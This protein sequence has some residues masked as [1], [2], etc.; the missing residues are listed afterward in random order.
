MKILDINFLFTQSINQ[1][2]V[3]GRNQ[4]KFLTIFQFTANRV[5]HDSNLIDLLI[6]DLFQKRGI[7]HFGLGRRFCRII[8]DNGYRDDDDQ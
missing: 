7:G 1:R 4:R 3:I 8:V 2:G 5:V 6:F